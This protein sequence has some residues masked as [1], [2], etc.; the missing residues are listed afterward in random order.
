MNGSSQIPMWQPPAESTGNR[1]DVNLIAMLL[2]QSLLTGVAVGI[3]HKDWYL[4]NATPAEMG[5]QYGLIAFGFLCTSMV[6]FQVGGIR[7]SMAMRAEFSKEASYDKWFRNQM[8]MTN[9]RM[10]KQQ[11][12]QELQGQ[13]AAMQ[14]QSQGRDVFGLPNTPAS[15][16]DDG[17]SNN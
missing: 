13:M 12:Y 8:Q 11:Y 14:Q 1:V 5:L 2:W 7:D 16:E 4:P 3:S 15:D 10:Q 17:R 6:L 9:R